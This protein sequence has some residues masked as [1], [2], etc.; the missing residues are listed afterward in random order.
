MYYQIKKAG[1]ADIATIANAAK[2]LH[3]ALDSWNVL[4]IIPVSK[5]VMYPAEQVSD[6]I[7]KIRKERDRKKFSVPAAQALDDLNRGL[8]SLGIGQV[9]MDKF[10]E[11]W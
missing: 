10:V 1:V 5:W 8:A 6:D 4:E 11:E 2:R 9:S 7:L 3:D